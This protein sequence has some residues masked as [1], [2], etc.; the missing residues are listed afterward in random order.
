[1]SSSTAPAADG[2][3]TINYKAEYLGG[4]EEQD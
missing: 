4:L 2:T 3:N 1:M